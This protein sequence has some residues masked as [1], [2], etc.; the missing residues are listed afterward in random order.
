MCRI[1]S[2]QFPIDYCWVHVCVTC[3]NSNVCNCRESTTKRPVQSVIVAGSRK[4][5]TYFNIRYCKVC[6]MPRDFFGL[7][8]FAELS[9]LLWKHSAEYMGR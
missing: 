6:S 5:V 4:S 3:T 2:K 7:S 9:H 1:G 8:G